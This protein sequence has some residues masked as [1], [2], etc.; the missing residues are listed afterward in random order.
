[1]S[2]T[3]GQEL[4]LYEIEQSLEGAARVW[5]D[6]MEHTIATFSEFET[7]FR[8]RFWSEAIQDE[9]ARKVEYLNFDP[10]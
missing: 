8:Q 1:M 2:T 6:V 5:Y 10:T 7:R 3:I 9:C 4:K